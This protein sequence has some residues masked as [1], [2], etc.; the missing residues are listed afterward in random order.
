MVDP[1]Q[2]AEDL[3]D[4]KIGGEFPPDRP[5]AVEDEG[6]TGVEQL[7]GES[8]AERD[9]RSEP[10]IWEQPRADGGVSR[11][12]EPGVELAGDEEV[13]VGDDEATMVA[14]AAGDPAA[15]EAG[16][17]APDDEFTGDETRRNVA[18]ERAASPAEEAA[19]HVD[20]GAPGATP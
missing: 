19:V 17:L 5:M 10:E 15:R 1:D 11:G 20:D 3:D 7:G 14:R 6:V 4:D 2:P 16:S 18:T 12:P 9:E 8:F 13:G